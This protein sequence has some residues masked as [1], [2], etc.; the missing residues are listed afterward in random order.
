MSIMEDQNQT[1]EPEVISQE[2]PISKVTPKERILNVLG[3][4]Y[5][6]T[7]NIANKCGLH[8]YRVF[9]FLKYLKQENKVEEML[10]N[11]Y[12]YW[13]LLARQEDGK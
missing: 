11:K 9:H 13:K 12:T 5:L 4:E 1:V 3:S 2:K 7:T 8:Y 6:T 10:L